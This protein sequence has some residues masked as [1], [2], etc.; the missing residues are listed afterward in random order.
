MKN[1]ALVLRFGS[2]IFSLIAFSVIISNSEKRVAAGSIFYVKFSDYQ[3]YN[4]LT[5][6]NLLTFLYSSGQLILLPQGRTSCIL[7]S[8]IKWGALLYLCDQMLAFLMIS[9]SSS[10]A[11]ASAL[12]R[13]GLH[14]IWPPACSTW[15]LT[16]FCSRADVALFHVF[17]EFC[18][19]FPWDT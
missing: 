5:A 9:S 18:L 11:T 7:S 8:P 15:K 2:A 10:A 16:L 17:S 13:H 19:P 14:N 4:Y 3:A 12:S 1:L 6:I